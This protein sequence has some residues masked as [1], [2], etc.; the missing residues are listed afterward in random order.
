MDPVAFRIGPLPIHWYGILIIGGAVLGAWISAREAKKRGHNP[1][2]VW[3]LLTVVLIL[4]IIGARLYHVFSQ[5]A[6][7][8][9]WDYYKENPIDII[10]FWK[11]LSTGNPNDIGFRGLGIYGGVIGGVIGVL[12]YTKLNKLKFVEWADIA[13]PA[14]LLAQAIGRWG[15]FVNQELFGPPT[16]LPWGISIDCLYR[17]QYA[18]LNCSVL[19][20][21]TRFHPTFLYESLWNVVGFIIVMTLLARYRSRLVNGDL[22]FFYLIW[23]PLGRFWIETWFRPDAWTLGALPAASVF[24]IL[25]ALLG[26]AGLLYNRRFQPAPRRR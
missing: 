24:S 18:G 4:G 16:N 17:A 26:V 19:G 12:L 5:P 1:D 20:P 23:Y 10:A 9:G 3:N 11:G 7:G 8:I 21:D 22:L 13:V 15:N 6:V 2:H 14:L 25:A